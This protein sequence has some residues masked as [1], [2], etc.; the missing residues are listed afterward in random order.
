MAAIFEIGI[1]IAVTQVLAD[2]QQVVE[3]M[4][5]LIA[6]AALV[7]NEVVIGRVALINI[8]NL[9]IG[10]IVEGR[11]STGLGAGKLARTVNFVSSSGF[12]VKAGAM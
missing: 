6:D 10:R 1:D 3:A 12:S 2:G 5:E 9:A 7:L 11:R 8:R 4:F